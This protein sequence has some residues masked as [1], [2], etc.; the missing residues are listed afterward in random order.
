MPPIEYWFTSSTLT[1]WIAV[2]AA[3]GSLWVA[4]NGDWQASVKEQDRV[5]AEQMYQQ[6][7]EFTLGEVLSV[8]ADADRLAYMQVN[9]EIYEGWK[10]NVDKFLEASSQRLKPVLTAAELAAVFAPA[11][12]SAYIFASSLSDEHSQ[13]MLR[14]TEVASRLR[15]VALKYA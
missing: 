4:I 13:Y 9:E 10:T 1:L 6:A 3:I 14:L 8:S 2:L 15:N 7:R 11:S 12:P 5:A